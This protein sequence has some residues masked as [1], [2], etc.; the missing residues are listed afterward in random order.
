MEIREMIAVL[1]TYPPETKIQ[2]VVLSGR[3]GSIKITR[4][5]EDYTDPEVSI[6]VH[7]FDSLDL[8][9]FEKCM[10]GIA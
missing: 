1:E 5:L 6:M 3:R 10:A 8:A 9:D 2:C 4:D 7:H